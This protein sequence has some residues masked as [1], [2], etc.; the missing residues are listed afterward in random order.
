V[1]LLMVPLDAQDGGLDIWLDTEYPLVFGLF[2]NPYL[3]TP[4]SH[5]ADFEAGESTYPGYGRVS[6]MP[7]AAGQDTVALTTSC[8]PIA[9]AFRGPSDS[10][11]PQVT[12]WFALKSKGD[13]S[14]TVLVAAQQFDDAPLT[15]VGSDDGPVFAFTIRLRQIEPQ[16]TSFLIDW[17]TP[18]DYGSPGDVTVTAIDQFGA[19]VTS[20]NGDVTLS[21]SVFDSP[22]GTIVPYLTDNSYSVV[23]PVV[24]LTDGAGEQSCQISFAG[25]AP[26]DGIGAIIA[27]DSIAVGMSD[28]YDFGP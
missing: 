3:P 12:G 7:P 19:P 25:G 17:D 13:G 23:D 27:N 21:L 26:F 2:E 11:S 15:L 8:G 5:L 16:V 18:P 10:S 1:G 14:D 28:T 9:V 4:V 6:V 24:T 22:S 20:Y